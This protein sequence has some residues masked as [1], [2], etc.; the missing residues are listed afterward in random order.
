MSSRASASSP[1]HVGARMELHPARAVDEVEERRL[2]LSAARGQAPGDPGA[3][4]GLLAGGQVLVRRLDV[5]DRLHAREGVRER[6]D[7]G[8]AELLELA[9]PIDQHL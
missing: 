6:V 8:G 7:A 9:P 2:A 3:V 4:P 1:E 5:R